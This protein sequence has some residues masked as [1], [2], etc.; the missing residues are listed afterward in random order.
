MHV[1]NLKCLAQA[2]TALIFLSL[3]RPRTRSNGFVWQQN[4]ANGAVEL[5]GLQP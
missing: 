4:I 5:W 2:F 3:E 1:V